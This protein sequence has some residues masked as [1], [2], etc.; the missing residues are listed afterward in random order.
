[1]L[2]A[3]NPSSGKRKCPSTTKK[4]SAP[5]IPSISFAL[6][7]LPPSPLRYLQV[8]SLVIPFPLSALY[9]PR[10]YGMPLPSACRFYF[11]GFLFF[12]VSLCALLCRALQ[13]PNSASI[14]LLFY[15]KH[16]VSATAQKS[17]SPQNGGATLSFVLTIRHLRFLQFGVCLLLTSQRYSR[18]RSEPL[19]TPPRRPPRRGAYC[20]RDPRTSSRKPCP[21]GDGRSKYPCRPRNSHRA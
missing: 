7:G 17:R 9:L 5:F 15:R 16:P 11:V 3:P 19:R 18:V 10:F 14:P 6:T 8:L 21:R 2:L 4:I 13:L 12:F 20:G 1:M